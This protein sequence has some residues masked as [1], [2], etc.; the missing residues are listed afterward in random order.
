MP[1]SDYPAYHYARGRWDALH[2]FAMGDMDSAG[3]GH[4]VNDTIPPKELRA[5]NNPDYRKD[6]IAQTFR[7]NESLGNPSK[8]NPAAVNPVLKNTTDNQRQYSS[9]SAGG[10]NETADST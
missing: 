4:L 5:E 2:K 6:M 7:E 1:L 8:G 3:A 9:D 10:I